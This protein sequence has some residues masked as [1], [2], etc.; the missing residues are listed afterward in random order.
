MSTASMQTALSQTVPLPAEKI[1]APHLD[2]EANLRVTNRHL[3]IALLV[4]GSAYLCTLGAFAYFTKSI[5]EIRPIIVRVNPDGQATVGPSSTLD[6]N[7]HEAEMKYF[8][9]HFTKLHYSRIRV[10]A[11]RSFDE[12]LFFVSEDLAKV[13]EE[14]RTRSQWL[15]KFLMGEGDEIEVHPTL[16]SIEDLR[17]PT[18]R[19]SVDFDMAHRERGGLE[20]K[21]SK[22]RVHYVFDF[23]DDVDPKV[24]DVNPLGFRITYFRV[25]EASR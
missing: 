6:Y 25:D 9:R 4:I 17:G 14:D 11:Q 16:T 5:R 10:T 21:R 23:H 19:A 20:V 3:R 15:A 8:L 7:P 2:I 12:K 24:R 13:M 18:Y 1:G 22:A